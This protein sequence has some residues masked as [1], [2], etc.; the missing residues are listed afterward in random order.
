MKNL[1]KKALVPALLV[2][3]LAQSG[4]LVKQALDDRKLDQSKYAD[5]SRENPVC[6]AEQ[7]GMS[8]YIILEADEEAK[9]YRGVRAL[10]MFVVP[11][12]ISMR[13]LNSRKDLQQLDCRTGQPVGK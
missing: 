4:V 11:M 5:I 12:E 10:L 6:L 9:V 7:G 1:L 13:D 2:I 3:S 8:A